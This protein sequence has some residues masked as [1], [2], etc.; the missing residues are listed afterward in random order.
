MSE[1]RVIQLLGRE[2]RIRSDEAPEHLQALG[3]YV[4]DKVQHKR[5]ATDVGQFEVIYAGGAGAMQAF[6]KRVDQDTILAVM[7]YLA[8]LQAA[9][10]N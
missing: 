4:D 6:G 1:T 2:L 7:A 10:G 8:E 5:V 3:R 9:A